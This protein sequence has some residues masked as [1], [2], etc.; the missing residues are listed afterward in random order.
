MK[1]FVTGG[2]G[3]IGAHF[4]RSAIAQGHDV[5]ALRR[6]GS[7]PRIESDPEPKWLEAPLDRVECCQLRG[8]DALAHFASAGVS[9]QRASWQDLMQ[10]NINAPMMLIQE[11]ARAGIARIVAAGIFAEYGRSADRYDAIPAEAPLLP[12]GAYAAS[13][14]AFFTC[15]HGLAIEQRLE[16]CYLRV[17]SAYG[18]GQY[19]GNLWPALR[20]AAEEGRDFEMT[21]G[22]QVR[23]F[24]AVQDVAD[25]FLHALVREVCPG[26]PCVR[27]VGSGQP[28]TVRA[29]CER[30]WRRWDARGQLR[31]GAL[32]YRP[33]EVMRF[34]PQIDD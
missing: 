9:P 17:F 27:N 15:L 11:A 12:V 33:N 25:A 32:P 5:T 31:V 34:V 16:V 22:G 24:V 23:D 21:L 4:L 14:A 8:F 29:F 18:E 26:N 20:R 28:M 30:W 13:K 7:R 6:A 10:W 1:I 3:F 19:E 2:T